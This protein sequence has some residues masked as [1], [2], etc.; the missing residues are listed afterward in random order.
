MSVKFSNNG[1]TV[2]SSGISASDTTIPVTDASVFPTITG[3]EYFYVTLADDT[4]VEILKVT[5]VSSNNLTVT[6]AQEG[7][8]AR[9]FASGDKAENRLTAGS[10]LE[11]A[12]GKLDLTGGTVTGALTVEGNL[13]TEGFLVA[14]SG[15]VGAGL[16]NNDGHGNAALTYNHTSGTPEQNGHSARIVVNTD[17]TTA[18]SIGQITFEVS[19][20]LVTAN[21]ATDLQTGFRVN[22]NYVEVPHKIEHMTDNDTYIQFTDDRI[23]MFAGGTKTYDSTEFNNTNWDTAYS[24][25]NHASAGYLTSYTETDTLD[26]VTGRG[27]TTTN[28]IT[29][30]GLTVDTD[31]LYV[32]ATN[33]RVGINESSPT[34]DLHITGSGDARLL[35]EGTGSQFPTTYNGVASIKLNSMQS[36]GL[37]RYAIWDVQAPST[38]FEG[39]TIHFTG[40]RAVSGVVDGGTTSYAGAT[41]QFYSGNGLAC[42]ISDEGVQAASFQ[43]TANGS[44]TAITLSDAG[45]V[46]TGENLV[47]TGALHAGGQIMNSS[48]KLQVNGFQRTGTIYLHEGATPNAN[49][50]ALSTNSSGDLNWDGNKVWHAGNDGSSSGLDADTVDGIQA[51]SFLRSDADDQVS[52]YSNNIRFYSNTAIDSTSGNQAS[53]EVFQPTAGSDA[54]MAFHVSNDYAGYFGID[55]SDNQFKVGGWSFGENK[56]TVYHQGNTPSLSLTAR[57]HDLPAIHGAGLRFWNGNDSYRIYMASSGTSGAGRMSGET[58]SDY[59]MYFRMTGGTNRG[60]VFQNSTSNKAGIDAS[61]NARF[62]GNV[63]AYASD[64]RL[65]ENVKTIEN[66]LEKLT[67]I[68]GVTFDWKDDIENF[69]PKCKTETGVIAQEIEAVIPDAISPAP[70]NEEYK[71]VEKDKIIALLIEAV[72]ELKAEVDELKAAK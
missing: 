30:G 71:T 63:T 56:Y 21:T 7:T 55:G 6:R 51:S 18:G 59:N 47:V 15:S 65:K 24:W 29:V 44:T 10:L 37:E 67:Q 19:D 26:S 8:T 31:T 34:E 4:N 72:K 49:N 9:A 23:R 11:S 39:S 38:N 57:N 40:E 14:G 17:T 2:L 53:L 61:G 20:A 3:S 33:D 58:S 69:D 60:F 22:H 46:T 54:F 42:K 13:T 64:E 70:F 50:W 35:I 43:T 68:R 32:D 36:G 12:S 62:A 5:G 66:P 16:T 41:F 25:G 28:A 45:R 52:T 27:A 48:A 1:K